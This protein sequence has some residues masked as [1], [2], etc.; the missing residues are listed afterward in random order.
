[1]AGRKHSLDLRG[2]EADSKRRRTEAEE[3]EQPD[4]KAQKREK[5]HVPI[6]PNTIPTAV[7]V[8]EAVPGPIPVTNAMK[9][10][11]IIDAVN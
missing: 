6:D 1:M 2:D 4:I 7:H 9:Q 3:D 10:C 11:V 8:A 5:R